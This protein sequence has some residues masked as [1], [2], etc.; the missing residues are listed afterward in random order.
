MGEPDVAVLG[1]VPR[2]P[3]IVAL[4]NGTAAYLLCWE[5]HE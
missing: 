4:G 1:E 2:S 5:Q 3:P